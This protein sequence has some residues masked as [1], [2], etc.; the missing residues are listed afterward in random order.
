MNWV[1]A[2]D[3]KIHLVQMNVGMQNSQMNIFQEDTEI[4]PD[5]AEFIQSS[6]A[7]WEQ[8]WLAEEA[9]KL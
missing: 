9:K 2:S 5:R 3:K 8:E 4:E 6:I 1:K 7:K